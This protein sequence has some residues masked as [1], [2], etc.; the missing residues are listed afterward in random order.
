MRNGILG[1]RSHGSKHRWTAACTEVDSSLVMHSCNDVFCTPGCQALSP[2]TRTL[3]CSGASEGNS[4]CFFWTV[5]LKM[6]CIWSMP[7]HGRCPVYIS[8]S[9][10]PKEYVSAA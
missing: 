1:K 10:T 5:T 3:I 6:I 7:A 4:S 9:N 2:R 8:H